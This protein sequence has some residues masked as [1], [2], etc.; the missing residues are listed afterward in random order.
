VNDFNREMLIVA[1]ESRRLT[2]TE[3]ASEA[4]FS[5][6]E[7]SKFET[8]LKIP[9]EEQV[10]RLAACLLY[11][12]SFFYLSES[13]RDFGSGC[14]YHRKRKTAPEASLKFLLALVNIK[15][16]QVKQLL[17]AVDSV[18]EYRF[19]QLDIDEHE[20]SA[21]KVAQALRAIWKLPPGPVQDVIRAIENAGG[22]VVPYD[23]GTDK[24]DALSQWL[25]GMPPLFLVNKRIPAD[26]LRFTLSHEI[27]HI[28]MHRYPTEDMEREADEFAAEFLMPERD[29]KSQLYDV[30]LVKLAS[31]KPYWR[32]SMNALL[33]RAG[34][35]G[36]ITPR[37][38][39]YLWMQMGKRGYRTHEPIDIA[40]E[41]PSLLKELLDIHRQNFGLGSRELADM[42]HATE[43][44]VIREYL[45]SEP[46][47][48]LRVI[49][50]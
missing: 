20:N 50:W 40:P 45:G 21:V 34:D 10:R 6:A 31:L 41:K 49:R 35:L 3:L 37:N 5:Q 17:K 26:R 25:P 23:F 12:A 16:I 7:I 29:I 39:T 11:P 14:V 24:I 2:Q 9:T 28:V 33:K 30:S 47:R 19:E 42:M 8:G 22:I 15:R 38:R 48:K 43:D 4:S 44:D 27:G 32:V 46:P 1:R 13:I 18:A 36:T